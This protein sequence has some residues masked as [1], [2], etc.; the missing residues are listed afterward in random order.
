VPVSALASL[1]RREAGRYN[2][3][4]TRVS[5]AGE[6]S[7]PGREAAAR[8]PYRTPVLTEYGSVSKLTRGGSGSVNE[9]AGSMMMM[10]PCL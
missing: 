3:L 2:S 6:D 10:M 7:P 4:V 9:A 5:A 8:K 1:A